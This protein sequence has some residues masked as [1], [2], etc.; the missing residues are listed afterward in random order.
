[1]PCRKC[2]KEL[3]A[4][5]LCLD[6]QYVHCLI[7]GKARLVRVHLELSRAGQLDTTLH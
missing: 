3:A 5:F 7:K 1:M 6:D 2:T 4:G